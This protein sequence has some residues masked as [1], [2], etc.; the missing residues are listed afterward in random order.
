MTSLGSLVKSPLE[1]HQVLSS[2][3]Y[4]EN[5]VFSVEGGGTIRIWDATAPT[6]FHQISVV[7]TRTSQIPIEIAVRGVCCV[8]ISD[9]NEI[10]TTNLSSGEVANCAPVEFHSGLGINSRGFMVISCKVGHCPFFYDGRR[11]K[12]TV[13]LGYPEELVSLYLDD[14]LA[15]S[16]SY[17]AAL[18]VWDWDH[19]WGSHRPVRVLP[20]YEDPHIYGP[21]FAHCT[22][23]FSRQLRPGGITH[24]ILPGFSVIPKELNMPWMHITSVTPGGP[25]ENGGL[26]CNDL[27]LRIDE[28]DY[29][30]ACS[31]S[32]DF[33]P[34]IRNFLN[35]A[36]TA[37]AT[38]HFAVREAEPHSP[39]RSVDVIPQPGT[40]W[41]GVLGL[42][43]TRC[44][45]APLRYLLHYRGLTP[46]AVDLQ[47]QQD[48]IEDDLQWKRSGGGFHLDA[49]YSDDL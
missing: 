49:H 9:L 28:I 44:E 34:F 46:S 16:L 43:A 5:R 14:S 45:C 1:L 24:N 21:R 37:R 19:C 48:R 25:A 47:T 41:R 31:D 2:V 27:V 6:H 3:I 15:I 38:L 13:I 33:F 11:G 40:A 4:S 32:S 17:D 29:V 12:N 35:N 18:H 36:A 10:T 30:E 23:K 20:D 22:L 26:K 8:T 39:I 42:Q 7:E